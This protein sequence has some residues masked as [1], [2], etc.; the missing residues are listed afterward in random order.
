MYAEMKV[1]G[2]LAPSGPIDEGRDMPH[3]HVARD[4]R[5]I[6]GNDGNH[7][8]AIAAILEIERMPCLVFARHTEWQALREKIFASRLT[9]PDIHLTPQHAEHPDLVDLI[10]NA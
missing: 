8:F 3:V 1:N 7:R 4:G 9:N 6:F 2:F 10:A 5:I